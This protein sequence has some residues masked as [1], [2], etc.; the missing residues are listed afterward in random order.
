MSTRDLL[1][2]T[3]CVTIDTR[4]IGA[5]AEN[6]PPVPDAVSRAARE[7]VAR[8]QGQLAGKTGPVTRY[9]EPEVVVVDRAAAMARLGQLAGVAAAIATLWAAMTW[10]IA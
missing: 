8:W 7:A 2:S 5:A 9:V 4:P 6:R 10:A 1:R 3:D